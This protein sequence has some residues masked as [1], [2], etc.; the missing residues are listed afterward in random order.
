MRVDLLSVLLFMKKT[1]GMYIFLSA[2][3][4]CYHKVC[5]RFSHGGMWRCSYA[6]NS[7]GYVHDVV[8][9]KGGEGAS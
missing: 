7:C 3:V 6:H 2:L 8:M 9:Y 5:N 4:N 1:L